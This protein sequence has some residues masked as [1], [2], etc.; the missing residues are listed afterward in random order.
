VLAGC[1]R[2]ARAVAQA[3]QGLG[4]PIG[5]IAAGE[6]WHYGED[7]PLR[8]SLEDQ[9]GAGAIIHYL[10]GRKS[11]EAEAAQALFEHFADK[12]PATLRECGSGR[13]LIRKGLAEDVNLAG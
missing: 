11:P 1:L 3:A 12:L 13:E 8:P 9:L 2:N 5:V 6:R 4:Q 10:T 7:S